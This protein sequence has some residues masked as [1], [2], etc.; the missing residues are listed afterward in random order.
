MI[1]VNSLK[2]KL[3]ALFQKKLVRNTS[4]M[5]LGKGLSIFIQAAYF[6]IIARSL[7]IEQYGEFVAAVAAVKLVFPFAPWGSGQV[8]IKNV[9]RNK[10]LLNECWGNSLFITFI[11]SS[12]L[13]VLLV[14]GTK[15]FFSE[16]IS[17]LLIFIV[18]VSDLLFENIL[19]TAIHLFMAVS[20]LSKSSQLHVLLSLTRLIAAF[21]FISF[22]PK[23]NILIWGCLYLL[24]TALAALFAFLIVHRM[25]GLPKLK[26]SIFK[27][28]I[29]QGFYFSVSLSSVTIYNDVDKVILANL[30]TL[31]ATG[32]YGAAYRL[33][34]VGFVPVHSLLS[35][36]YADFFKHGAVG[37]SG[38]FNF[39]K[40]IF[41]IV[42]IFGLTSSIGLFFVAPIVPYILGQEYSLA[43]DALRWL[44][45]LPFLKAM[46]Y[47]AA[48]IFTGAG[49]QKLRSVIQLNM[50]IF[51]ALINFWLI[52]LYSWKGAAWCSLFSDGFLALILWGLAFWFNR[53]SKIE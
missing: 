6:I 31:E 37:I 46:N 45:P 10:E 9:S 39:A 36:T 15:I 44:A 28:E 26:L 38:S 17:P 51:N 30:S 3:S 12:V 22:F 52:P 19:V 40:R 43:L 2:L 41:P 33:V 25:F 11:C 5:L 14:L 23:G 49:L 42:G 53:H 27:P 24:S 7:G 34:N 48:D 50:A 16:I 13:T 18:A 32:I 1:N 29:I 20:L 35:A 47:L 8:L 21:I 4:Q